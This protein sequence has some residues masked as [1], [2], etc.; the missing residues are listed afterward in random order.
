MHEVIAAFKI[1][2]N[3]YMIICEGEKPLQVGVKL[4]TDVGSFAASEYAVGWCSQR[5]TDKSAYAT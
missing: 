5:I 4:Q 3:E 2:A 1:T